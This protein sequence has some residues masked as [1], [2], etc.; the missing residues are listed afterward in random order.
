MRKLICALTF[1]L[2]GTSSL[3]AQK[4]ISTKAPVVM[5]P[6]SPIQKISLKKIKGRVIDKINK[7]P[8]IAAKIS[9]EGTALSTITDFDGFFELEIPSHFSTEKLMFSYTGYQTQKVYVKHFSDDLV[10]ELG[11]AKLDRHSLHLPIA[12]NKQAKEIKKY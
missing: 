8:L 11:E 1:I 12:K 6:I 10:L 7:T 9:I 3:L 2:L 4:A 5:C